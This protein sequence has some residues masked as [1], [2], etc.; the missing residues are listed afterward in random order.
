MDSGIEL[1]VFVPSAES[2]KYAKE[3][4]Q[5]HRYK[6]RQLPAAVFQTSYE[7]LH[8]GK[9]PNDQVYTR[10]PIMELCN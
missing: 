3:L 9:V 1:Y 5:C 6:E 4:R 8:C 10:I 2:P 7:Q